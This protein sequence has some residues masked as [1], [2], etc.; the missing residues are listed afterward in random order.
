MIEPT[1]KNGYQGQKCG[2]FLLGENV[3]LE[4]L[5]TEAIEK[6]LT[7]K[8]LG[9]QA[10]AGTV[11]TINEKNFIISKNNILELYTTSPENFISSIS[12]FK[13]PESVETFTPENII[14]DYTIG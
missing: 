4:I 3:A 7:I 12:F 2:P 5:N 11:V 8:H 1:N 13:E 6:N 14:I 10:P 9:I